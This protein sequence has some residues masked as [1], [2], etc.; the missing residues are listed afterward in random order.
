V[1]AEKKVRR[2]H[3]GKVIGAQP[4]P[5]VD[6]RPCPKTH[7]CEHDA[8]KGDMVTVRNSNK[9]SKF[10]GAGL[11]AERII[12]KMRANAFSHRRKA[13]QSSRGCHREHG[14]EP[15]APANDTESDVAIIPRFLGTTACRRK[16]SARRSGRR[17]SVRML[18]GGLPLARTRQA[19]AAGRLSMPQAVDGG[20]R[21]SPASEKRGRR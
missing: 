17:R 2:R 18:G 13:V 9:L 14:G 12:P 1:R 19:A 21:K 16:G 5:F 8:N 10:E 11:L 4:E 3:C 6:N 7:N 15:H 20:A